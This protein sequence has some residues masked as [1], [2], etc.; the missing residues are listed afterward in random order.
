MGYE[1]T[2]SDSIDTL[3]VH[4]ALV[5]LACLTGY[6]IQKTIIVLEGLAMPKDPEKPNSPSLGENFPLFPLCMVGGI[7]V[8]KLLR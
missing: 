5:G 6:G 8:D 1:T 7:I 4:A 2:V 3:S